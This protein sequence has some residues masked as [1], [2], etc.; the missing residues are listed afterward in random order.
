MKANQIQRIESW[1]YDLALHCPF[2]GLKIIDPDAAS[3]IIAGTCEHVLFIAHDEGFEYRS[4]RFDVLM[5]IEDIEND[6]L[7]LGENGYDGF[8]DN[9]EFKNSIKFALYMPAPSFL[10]SYIG[11]APVDDD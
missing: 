9:V 4:N 10:G 8:T 7:V 6:H 2:C 1:R 3:E 5:D 11:F